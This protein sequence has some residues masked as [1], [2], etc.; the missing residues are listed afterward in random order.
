M[1][2]NPSYTGPKDL[3][4]VIPVFPLSGALLLPRSEIPLNIFE[5][6]YL[7]MVEQA[8]AGNRLIGMVQPEPGEGGGAQPDLAHVGCVGR[9]TAFQETGDGRVLVT[10][11]G[12][13][14]FNVVEETTADTP[15]RTCR[16]DTKPFAADFLM[17]GENE[18]V[19]RSRLIETLEAYLEANDLDADW[20]DIDDMPS[21]LLVNLLS[22][23][24][25]YGPREK[26]A[27]L[28]AR[29]LRT[30]SEMLIA[31]TERVLMDEPN[32][33]TLQ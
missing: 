6:R 10:L 8:L 20:D 24:S 15:F 11:T 23:M 25:P 3:P 2:M 5:P 26:Q 12:I 30:R 1:A 16:I 9:I 17:P 27:L 29:D 4:E 28:E 14:R 32:G 31:I 13:T 7:A 22:M 21:E 33:E 19:D 18:G